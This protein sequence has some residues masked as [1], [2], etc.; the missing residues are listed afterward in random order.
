MSI[1]TLCGSTKFTEEMLVKQWELTKAGH[2]VLTW[3]VLPQ[4]YIEKEIGNKD[5]A[6]IGDQEGVKEAIDAV[7]KKKIDL[8]DE[9]LVINIGDYVGE[10]TKSEIL[11]ALKGGKTVKYLYPHEK[12][13]WEALK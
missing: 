2:V 5:I 8:S 12:R 11:H 6:H 9:V 10:S 4:S 13:D 7:H 3:C 1:I